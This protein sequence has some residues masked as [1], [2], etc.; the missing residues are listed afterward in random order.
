MP[1]V[2]ES[3]RALLQGDALPEKLA[4]LRTP[5][6]GVIDQLARELL[7]FHQDPAE[8]AVRQRL[9]SDGSQT[10][11]I[12]GQRG[13][14]KSTLLAAVTA[15]LLREG[16]HL[17]VP[18]M[19]PDQFGEPDSVIT[20]FLSEL[21]DLVSSNEQQSSEELGTAK[22]ARDAEAVKLLADVARASAVARTTT[23]ALEHGTESPIDFADDFLTVSRSG[24]R[25]THQ[26]REL[27]LHLCNPAERSEESRLIIVPIDDPDLSRHSIISI[28]T[29]LQILSAVPGIVP[30]TC[31]S[32]DDLNAAWVAE[33]HRLLPEA[34]DDHLRF[35]L[36]R[37][38]EKAFP[39]RFRFEIEPIAPSQRPVF[40]P[41]AGTGTLQ[42]KLT[43]LRDEVEKVSQCIWA[44]DES[45]SLDR[46][47][48]GVRSALPDNARTLVQVWETLD[49]LC[50]NHEDTTAELLHLTL[51]RL[52]SLIGEPVAVRL[53]L[54]SSS[55]VQL[56]PPIADDASRRALRFDFSGIDFVPSTNAE[57][58]EL[59]EP[60]LLA[61]SL[62]KLSE[63]RAAY[64]RESGKR[65]SEYASEDYLKAEEATAI[66]ALQ[67]IGHGS[68]LFDMTGYRL[69]FSTDDWRFLQKVQLANQA[70]DDVFLLLPDA[71]T[72]SEILRSGALWN[73][74]V[75][76]SAELTPIQLFAT[77]IEAACLTVLRDEDLTAQDD[78]GN[79][80][81]RAASI[82][83][84]CL[85][86]H[87]STARAFV[88]WFERDLPLQWHSGLLSGEQI[89]SFAAKHKELSAHP[90]RRDYKER[91][92]TTLFETR[93]RY[94]LDGL[95]NADPEDEAS[96]H[97]WVAGY[98]E[99]A[100]A[101]NSE[102]LERL[103]RVYSRWQ[104]DSAGVRAGAATVG[105]LERKPS[106]RVRAAPYA[107]PEATELVS[108]AI[109]ALRRARR[110]AHAESKHT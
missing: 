67:E 24:V 10:V 105:S 31:F 39:Y 23:S 3:I 18:I 91:I 98:F 11:A 109:A 62:R 32:P 53:G 17:I 110:A 52:F 36:A 89:R 84:E 90:A 76:L 73:D 77:G 103:S 43:V 86:R 35:L 48:F 60:S 106:T 19:R 45:F 64:P 42:N 96:R 2:N 102:Q 63:V 5:M 92:D 27:A 81:R 12:M 30:L 54:P 95:E 7:T 38:M 79:A 49:A 69:Y 29:D 40:T 88:Q 46:Q 6:L 65:R 99:L 51:R 34:S 16:R 33:R 83:E 94:L 101:L 15:E 41:I 66:L 37:Q 59:T 4:E 71:T 61:V 26:L 93:L 55:V 108:T 22:V 20:T 1:T 97:S 56:G 57:E 14:G 78:Y 25:L 87:G 28:L 75:D 68:G 50:P 72:L 58:A 70:T 104:R 100:S 47:V 8:A 9:L 13:S 21:W 107:T 74:L 85:P 80:F 44:I 82:Y